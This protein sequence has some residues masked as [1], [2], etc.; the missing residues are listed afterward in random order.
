MTISAMVVV[1][2]KILRQFTKETLSGGVFP[3]LLE[4]S[5]TVHICVVNPVAFSRRD[6]MRNMM[7]FSKLDILSRIYFSRRI[8]A[9]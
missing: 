9:W 8:Y 2:I 4:L 5:T 7:D 3:D 6:N 1:L